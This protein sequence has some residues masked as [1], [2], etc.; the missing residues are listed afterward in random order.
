MAKSHRKH[1]GK[2]RIAPT[3]KYNFFAQ[4]DA[5]YMSKLRAFKKDHGIKQN[6]AA[7]K[8]LL[9]LAPKHRGKKAKALTAS[10]I[11]IKVGGEVVAEAQGEPLV[12]VKVG[13]KP[14]EIVPPEKSENP[15]P[16]VTPT[17]ASPQSQGE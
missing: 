17:G 9:D 10:G 2:K 7:L 1:V 12:A 15:L 16:S 3:P 13:F 14:P 11:A 6:V 4:L 5:P 8:K